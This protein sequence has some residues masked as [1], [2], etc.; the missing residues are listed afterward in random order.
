MR[1]RFVRTPTH[2]VGPRTLPAWGKVFVNHMKSID[3][4]FDPGH[5]ID[6]VLRVTNTALMLAEREKAKLEV[7]L[8]AVML[9]D[10]LPMDKFA[11]NSKDASRISAENSIKLLRDWA[12][13]EEFL[14]P[15]KHAIL[16]HSFSASIKPETLEAKV[17][18]DADRLDA[19]GAIGIARTLA[20]GFKQGNPLYNFDEPFPVE[21]EADDHANIL[22]HF[23]LKLLTLPGS[24]H[25]EAAKQE[26]VLR[27]K[28]MEGFLQSLAR[29]IGVNYISYDDYCLNKQREEKK[30]LRHNERLICAGTSGI[31]TAEAITHA[32]EAGYRYFDL[33]TAYKGVHQALAVA[34]QKYDRKDFHICTKINDVDLMNHNFSVQ[35]IFDEILRDLKSKGSSL[36]TGHLN[37][38]L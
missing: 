14:E 27:I 37:F 13:P 2:M 6:H 16:A 3:Q 9:H 26:A 8:P 10:S 33:A 19:L 11:K 30:M 12:Y 15:V 17:V 36:D 21:R 24:L 5:R 38:I 34:M 18:Q 22:D 20:V 29:E 25:T 32:I 23:Y 1:P 35:Q 31:N 4:H 28:T 7:V